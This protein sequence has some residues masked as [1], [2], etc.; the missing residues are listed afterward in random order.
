MT[1]R[2]LFPVRAGVFPARQFIHAAGGDVQN[3]FVAVRLGLLRQ[4]TD[5]RP[6]VA[7]DGAGVRSN[8]LRMM[9]K[10]VVLPA[11]FGPTSAT[12]SP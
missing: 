3:G 12:R 10:S 5:H 7:L 2:R 6:F 1:R 4:I 9:E 8:C 11:P